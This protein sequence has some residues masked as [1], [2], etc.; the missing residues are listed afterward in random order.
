MAS[1]YVVFLRDLNG[2]VQE[3]LN[4]RVQKCTLVSCRAGGIWWILVVIFQAYAVFFLP[5]VE[6]LRCC[7]Q[8]LSGA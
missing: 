2:P 1:E 5:E 4:T 8:A 3:T 7:D 6:A